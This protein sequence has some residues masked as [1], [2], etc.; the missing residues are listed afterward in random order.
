MK[1]RSALDHADTAYGEARRRDNWLR[2]IHAEVLLKTAC[3]MLRD[4]SYGKT[5]PFAESIT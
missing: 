4:R 2:F 1:D 5:V 3:V